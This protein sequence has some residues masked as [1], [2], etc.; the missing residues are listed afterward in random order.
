M[1]IN[2][3]SLWSTGPLCKVSGPNLKLVVRIVPA[4]IYEVKINAN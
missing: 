2:D 3:Q 1:W 4:Q